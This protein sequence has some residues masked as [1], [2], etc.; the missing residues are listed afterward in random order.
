MEQRVE[1]YLGIEDRK[2]AGEYRGGLM[3][4]GGHPP[5]IVFMP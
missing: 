5:R 3:W 1:Q 4:V 2:V